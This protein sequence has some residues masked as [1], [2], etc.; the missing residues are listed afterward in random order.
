MWPFV[1]RFHCNRSRPFDTESASHF[2]ELTADLVTLF[3]D[4]LCGK[5]CKSH[6]K[7]LKPG[8]AKIIFYLNRMTVFMDWKFPKVVFIFGIEL[9]F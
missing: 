2:Y 7:S 4:W 8:A 1:E 9:K 5:R 3:L 6:D